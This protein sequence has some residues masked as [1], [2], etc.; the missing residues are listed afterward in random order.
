MLLALS[1]IEVVEVRSLVFAVIVFLGGCVG[2]SVAATEDT[3]TRLILTVMG[4]LAGAA[5]GGALVRL[6]KRH[7]RRLGL[8]GP[9]PG[10]GTTPE[11]LSA[12]FWRDKGHPPFMKPPEQDS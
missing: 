9:V 8:D 7:A 6:G 10:N 11:D 12:N 3:A 4:C 5:M 2:W 1:H